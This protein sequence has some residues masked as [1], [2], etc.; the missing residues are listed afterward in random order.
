MKVAFFDTRKF[1]KP[2]Y[3]NREGIEFQYFNTRLSAETA[4]LSKGYEA[5][6]GFVND[7]IDEGCLKKLKAQGV[8]LI[9]LRCAG[10]N[11]VNLLMANELG[12]KIT[13]VPS[14][15]PHS[16][17]EFALLQSLT[18]LRKIHRSY[19]RTREL[20]FSLDGLVGGT[21]KGKTFGVLGLGQ[22]GQA[23]CEILAGFGCEVL[24]YDIEEKNLSGVKQV[25]LDDIIKQSD[26]IS[27]HVPLTPETHHLIDSVR[28]A[29]MKDG[30]ILLNTG[31]GGLIH[32]KSL[33]DGL[34]S[35]KIAGAA[36]DVYEEEEKFF[37]EDFSTTGID[38][39]TLARLV[40]FPNVL[41]TSHQG[42][43][44]EESLREI[45]KATVDSIRAWEKGLALEYEITGKD[46]VK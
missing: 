30:V 31:R 18:L 41:I 24:G 37:F 42:F 32:S 14:Y 43:L 12:I 5:I 21:L 19:I 2:F 3:E 25:S 36:L 23:L 44:T 6:C 4:E 28:I 1:E 27:L 10:Y 46:E 38:D 8:K 40:T 7:K 34:K 35:K 39:D 45:S 16:V 13:R 29:Q 20:N 22:I 9:A 33:I 26:I 17:A 15:S 11:N